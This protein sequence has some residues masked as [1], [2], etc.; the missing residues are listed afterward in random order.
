ME[1]A[2][3]VAESLFAAALEKRVAAAAAA[4]AAATAERLALEAEAEAEAA[5]RYAVFL[6]QEG[7]EET[8]QPF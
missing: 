4:T 1:A 8:E 3:D 6:A 2:I 7:E 5:R